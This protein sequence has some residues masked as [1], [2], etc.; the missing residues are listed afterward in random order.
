MYNPDFREMQ[1]K[2]FITLITII[3]FVDTKLLE[4]EGYLVYINKTRDC[5]CFMK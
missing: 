3:L 4:L 1:L 5:H 2:A